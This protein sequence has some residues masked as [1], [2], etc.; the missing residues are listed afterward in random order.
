MLRNIFLT[1]LVL[2]LAGT[3]A[4]P[5]HAQTAERCFAET[6]FCLSGRFREY[7]EQNGGLPIFGYPITAAQ[8]EP[9]RDTGA[10]HL[11]QYFERA[12]FELHP[13]L[14]RP[15]DVL[16]GRLGDDQLRLQGIDW[17]AE[18]EDEPRDD[19]LWFPET[20]H[21]VC[22]QASGLGFKSYWQS[23][24]LVFD[25]DVGFSF[26]ESLALFGL[27]LTGARVETNSSG[28]TVLTQW[29]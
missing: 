4:P 10:T 13:D 9:N 22:D 27:P 24:G 15:Y 6:G 16:L 8:D 23:H 5:I 28:D 17:Q 26:A 14:A 20:R 18:P 3:S 21:S 11:T 2:F 1:V 12:R 19:C 29:F 7:W 25:D